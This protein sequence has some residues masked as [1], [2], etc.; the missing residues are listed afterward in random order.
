MHDLFINLILILNMDLI[1]SIVRSAS[2]RKKI[3]YSPV[4]RVL[5]QEISQ[6]VS[7]FI[8]THPQAS[9]AFWLVA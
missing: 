1:S 8:L 7:V 6:V 2:F 4:S 5:N 9:S 3:A